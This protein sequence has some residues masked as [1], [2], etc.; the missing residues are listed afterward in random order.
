[1]LKIKSICSLDE[2]A[3]HEAG[4][5]VIAH[6]SGLR[7]L[8]V[9]VIRDYDRN[10]WAASTKAMPQH[11]EPSKLDTQV[12]IIAASKAMESVV[13]MLA[14]AKFVAGREWGT[15]LLKFNLGMTDF[16]DLWT[17]LRVTQPEA[18]A[19]G[20]IRLEFVGLDGSVHSLAFVANECFISDEDMNNFNYHV[21]GK[22]GARPAQSDEQ[23]VI[24]A[25][26]LLDDENCWG[27]VSRLASVL[28]N[29]GRGN[30]LDESELLRFLSS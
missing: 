21:S 17:L 4:H 2:S 18:K 3:H 19:A 5:V 23:I 24:E 27:Q 28:V 16:G 1:M 29:D 12:P 22:L 10:R 9:R 30:Y 13:G 7:V 25:M 26:R 11:V 15:E 6:K 8:Y 14:Q 20:T